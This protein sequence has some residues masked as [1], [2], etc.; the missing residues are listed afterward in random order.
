MEAIGD[1]PWLVLGSFNTVLDLGK[2]CGA[3][4]DIAMAV[5]DFQAR[6][7]DTGIL[8]ILIQGVMFT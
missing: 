1:E 3:F 6:I 5:A 4:S 2:V 8:S 7:L